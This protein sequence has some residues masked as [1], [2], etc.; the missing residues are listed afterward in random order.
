[1]T[2]FED[3]R[4]G[5]EAKYRFDEEVAFRITA[6]R[7]RLFGLWV[8]AQLGL[9]GK[10]AE[11]YAES[12]VVADFDEPGD[13]DILTK[14]TGDLAAK[15]IEIGDRELRMALSRA[16]VEARTQIAEA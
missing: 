8:A 2:A 16:A 3:R 14:V 11:A 12:V 15:M 1:M 5:F 6:R 13:E 4:K 7:N 10:N 9:T